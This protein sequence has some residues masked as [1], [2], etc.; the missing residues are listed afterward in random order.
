MI[1]K[2]I[3]KGIN[4]L[5]VQMELIDQYSEEEENIKDYEKVFRLI[6][7]MDVIESELVLFISEEVDPISDEKYIDVS[8][9]KEEGLEKIDS[10]G[11]NQSYALEYIPWEEWLGMK[12]AK[13]TL[14]NFSNLE[15]IAHC[16]Y[17]MT[18][19]S[20]DQDEIKKSFDELNKQI[21]DYKSLSEEE[22]SAKTITLDELM[23]KLDAIKNIE[24]E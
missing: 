17:E 21:E 16:L 6:E 7:L 13:A 3:L 12:I 15:I 20:F 4:W 8:G 19:V 24:D 22:K 11:S 18:F 9:V 1:L 14:E 10:Q 2:E 5:H 23:E